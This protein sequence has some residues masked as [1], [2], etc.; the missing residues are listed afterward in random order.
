VRG[1]GR[2]ER[3]RELREDAGPSELL[4]A[5]GAPKRRSHG[6]YTGVNVSGLVCPFCHTDLVQDGLGEIVVPT[7]EAGDVLVLA[8][9]KCRAPLGFLRLALP[10]GPRP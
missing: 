7:V 3:H 5:A 9:K 8:C 4:E 6:R 2:S 10:K 1:V